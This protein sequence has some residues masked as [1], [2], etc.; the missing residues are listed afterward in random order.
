MTS[1]TVVAVAVR[2]LGDFAVTRGANRQALLDR[3]G[4][5]TSEL[6]D[7]HGRVAFDKYKSL[8]RAAKALCTDPAFALHFGES[9][10]LNEIS[11]AGAL[12]DISTIDDASEQVNRYGRLALDVETGGGGDRWEMKRRSGQRWVVDTRRYPY[13]FP[14]L[15]ES[16]FARVSCS[17][18][19]TTGDAVFKEIHVTHAEPS[20]RAEYDRIFR[21]PVV[22][23]SDEN[24]VRLD[25]SV[26]ASMKPPPSSRYV[27]EILRNEADAMLA[28]LDRAQSM[29]VRV[30]SVLIPLL[31]MGDVSI[32]TVGRNMGLSRQTLYRRL[33]D[34]GVTFAQVVEE[35]R[36]R[37]AIHYLS[38]NGSSVRET[39]RLVGYS[40]AAAFSRA[41]K[42]WT[43]RS[44]RE[45]ATR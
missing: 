20:Y 35:L 38:T 17:A 13:V 39:A 41:F 25:E 36:Y 26:L 28:E 8:T 21:I 22:F 18:R 7:P 27:Q 37:M 32:E 6:A 15:T 34:E 29:R 14:E 5:D 44:P 19:R 23:G 40:D 33:R 3:S 30:E 42:R 2:A 31:E 10:D 16:S 24:A 4:I 43:G 12:G 11:I 45:I 1:G 9:V